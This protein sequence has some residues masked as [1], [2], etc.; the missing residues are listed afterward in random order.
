[1]VLLTQVHVEGVAAVALAM[2]MSA[3]VLAVIYGWQE[4]RAGQPPADRWRRTVRAGPLDRDNTRFLD[5]FY[6][7]EQRQ[8]RQEERDRDRLA[9]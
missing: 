4:V 5:D 1:M 6:P 2:V 3:G 9:V 7:I 8:R